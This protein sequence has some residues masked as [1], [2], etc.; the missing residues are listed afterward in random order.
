MADDEKPGDKPASAPLPPMAGKAKDLEALRNAVVDAAN[1][2]GALW[3]SYLFVLLYFV[4]AVG[5]VT[6]RNL[7]FENPVKLP[8]LN[9]D[10]PLLAFFALGPLI[11]LVVHAYILLHF[12]MLADKVGAFHAELEAQI[13]DPDTRARLRRQLPSNI[14]VQFLAG[15]PEVRNGMMGAMLQMIGQISLLVGPLGLLTLF[16]LQFLAYHHETIL[17]WQRIAV[18]L[19]LALLWMLWPS[20]ARGETSAIVWRD[21]RKPGVLGAAA[22][23]AIPVLLVFTVA[24]FPGELLDRN[25]VSAPIIPRSEDGAI[26]WTTPHEF[27]VA[28]DIDLIAR[29]TTSIWSN[30][31]V[32]PNVE[33]PPENLSLR[34]RDLVGAILL[35]ARLG[36]VDFAAANLRDAT[37]GDSDLR[38]ANF[39]CDAKRIKAGEKTPEVDQTDADN[40]PVTRCT[41]LQFASF[42]RANMQGVKFDGALMEGTS[43]VAAQLQG[44]SMNETQLQGARLTSAQLQGA[45][46]DEAALSGSGLEGAHLEGASLKSA[47]LVG[48][49]LIGAQLQGVLLDS[50]LLNAASLDGAQLHGASLVDA[51]LKGA[52]LGINED[53]WP[54]QLQG[55]LVYRAQLQAAAVTSA[56]LWRSDPQDA[57]LDATVVKEPNAAPTYQMIDCY[58]DNLRCDWSAA[59][60][61]SLAELIKTTVPEGAYRG[62]ALDRIA[63]LDPSKKVVDEDAISR[64]W[65]DRANA[66][67]PQADYQQRLAEEFKTAICETDYGKAS[68]S[69]LYVARMI[70]RRIFPHRENPRVRP[71]LLDDTRFG[72]LATILLDE[73]RCPG[74]RDLSGSD[75]RLLHRF[76]KPSREPDA[77][78]KR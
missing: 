1:V 32:L 24:T 64:S 26:R 17:W 63:I 45:L 29:R 33:Q 7:L 39:G 59:S 61:A 34:G 75:M 68:Q 14:F 44:A 6:H 27:L 43:L 15:P 60:Y 55:A 21:F 72:E 20:V 49:S 77:A 22:I 41:Q 42:D 28:G 3:F 19:D 76:A 50:A 48:A 36:K 40:R 31:L 5:S 51:S 35:G 13:A 8:F 47:N 67:P 71:R 30:R 70:L 69:S 54:T 74:A 12:A 46:L 66:P 18:V 38:G 65:T 56:L 78:R 58:P 73:T 11:F 37:F 2:S 4:I 62:W 9:V 23:S 53:G 16:V 10:L 25:P 57:N 52:S